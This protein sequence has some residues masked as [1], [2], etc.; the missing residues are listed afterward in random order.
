MDSMPDFHI[1]RNPDAPNAIVKTVQV[2]C[3]VERGLAAIL[4]VQRNNHERKDG[5][6]EGVE[7]LMEICVRRPLVVGKEM[8]GAVNGIAKTVGY[9]GREK[10]G[11]S[12]EWKV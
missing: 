2:C 9:G 10:R 1:R 3:A 7:S 5:G 12:F 8:Q 11:S 4:E 6:E